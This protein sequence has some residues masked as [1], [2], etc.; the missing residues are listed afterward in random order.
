MK[1]D[2]AGRL[3]TLWALAPE[4]LREVQTALYRFAMGEVALPEKAPEAKKAQA[5]NRKGRAAVI[6][7]RGVL[8]HRT[9]WLSEYFGEVGT[10]DVGA[11]VDA[12]A[13][14]SEVDAIVL[15]IDSPGGSVYGVSEL[16]TKVAAAG[17][18]KKCIAAVSPLAA[19]GAYWVA[20]QCNEVC[21]TPS[22]EVGSIGVFLLHVDQ[23]KYLEERGVKVTPI[24]AG[25]LKVAGNGFE[26]LSED[27]R[28]KLQASV[29]DYYAQFVR[30]VATGRGVSM[31]KVREGFGQ[32]GTVRAEGAVT[33]GMADKV[34]TLESVLARYGSTAVKSPQSAGPIDI[35]VEVRKRLLASG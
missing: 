2:I 21:V 22:G 32:G 14:D 12:A 35:A 18:K 1:Y 33:E 9:D 3:A 24:S 16:A 20:S 26:P 25:K 29:D 31:V 34:C 6:P 8:V 27:G 11:L 30:A 28:A 10:E 4:R 23:S 7:V 13:D 17:A 5:T 19:S 15:A